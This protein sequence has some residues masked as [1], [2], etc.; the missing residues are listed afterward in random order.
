MDPKKDGAKTDASIDSSSKIYLDPNIKNDFGRLAFEEALQS[1]HAPIA[2]ML[3]QV[4]ELDDQKEYACSELD[5][6]DQVE[7]E[8]MDEEDI[9]GAKEDEIKD[10][11]VKVE[12]NKE[13]AMQDSDSDTA[14]MKHRREVREAK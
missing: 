12:Q 4:T 13:E 10:Q 14:S 1:G 11:K 2:D 9:F 6:N 5:E 3:A 8:N 7:M